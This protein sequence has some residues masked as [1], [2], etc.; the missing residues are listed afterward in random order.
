VAK[1]NDFA[2]MAAPC[3]ALFYYYHHSITSDGSQCTEISCHAA[4]NVQ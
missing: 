1:H 3:P 2:M 4:R